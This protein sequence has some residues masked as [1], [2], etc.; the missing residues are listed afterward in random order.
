VFFFLGYK[1]VLLALAAGVGGFVALHR[2]RI[3]SQESVLARDVETLA[4][5]APGGR[6]ETALEAPTTA[7][8]EGRATALP[9]HVCGERSLKVEEHAAREVNGERLRVVR[10][11]CTGCG[12]EREVFVRVVSATS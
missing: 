12:A 7:V 4:R 5:A 1:L 10:V 9:C 2:S 8:V 11:A 6:P 3:R